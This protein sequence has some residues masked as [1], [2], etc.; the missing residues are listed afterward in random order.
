MPVV[1]M[2]ICYMKVARIIWNRRSDIGQ[3]NNRRQLSSREAS[4][5]NGK[6]KMIKM[7]IVVVACYTACW[8]PI[9]VFWILP[10]TSI[11][12]HSFIVTHLL[13]LFHTCLN[14]VICVWMNARVR[15]GFVEALGIFLLITRRFSEWRFG[16]WQNGGQILTYWWFSDFYFWKF[17]PTPHGFHLKTFPTP[18]GCQKGLLLPLTGFFYPWRELIF[19]LK[20]LF[21]TPTNLLQIGKNG[22]NWSTAF[23]M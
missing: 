7:L 3:Q 14:P 8:L 1:L 15:C 11:D 23:S 2:S 13:A 12:P 16:D 22:L 18:H 17:F 4:M 19:S 9:N 21:L 6:R 10:H 5:M 20:K